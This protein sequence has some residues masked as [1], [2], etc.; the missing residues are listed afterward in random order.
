MLDLKQL[1]NNPDHYL[2]KLKEKNF[3]VNILNEL[4]SIVTLRGQKM[5]RAESLK[6]DLNK[7]S[8]II[9]NIKDKDEKAK[10]LD[11]LKKL[12]D[13]QKKL[14][15]EADVLNKSVHELLAQIPNVTIDLVPVGKDE[16]F[17]KVIFEKNNL[18]KGTFKS[19][20][21][22]YEIAE[23][24]DLIDFNR[25]VKLSGS[26]FIFYKNDG[27]KLIRA[28]QN[29]MLDFHE[30]NGF[31]EFVTPVIV[32]PQMLFGTGQ[33]PKFEEDLF[34]LNTN[35][36][37]IPTSEVSLTNYYNDEIINLDKVI[38]LTSYGDCFRSEI[39]SGGK[40]NHG[41]IRMHQFRKVEMVKFAKE[42]DA[43]KE[44]N[45][46]AEN[47]ESMLEELQIPHQKLLLASGDT[48]FSSQIT[49]D[50]E[51]WLPSENRYRETSSVSWMGEFQARRAQIR[52]RDQEG[53]VKYA[54]TMNGSGLALDRVVASILENG[55]DEANNWVE[56]PE[57]L[58]KY[59]GKKYLTKKELN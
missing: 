54:H 13:E 32:K 51:I 11:N 57:V 14:Q 9:V 25:G 38:R 53:N 43:E 29:Y 36:F 45:L 35:D 49:Y 39:G 24:L 28:L 59:L 22:H 30:K 46:M 21:S 33:L 1:I 27:A 18:W 10:T 20:I 55:Y 44:F 7:Y 31:Q 42:E 5:N 52:Y 4:L 23:K 8:K 12:K 6:A 34:K 37:L 56:V 17:N 47:A 58:V 19:E 3:D 41:I 26:R 2:K 48:G 15:D 50:Y 16:T 40:D